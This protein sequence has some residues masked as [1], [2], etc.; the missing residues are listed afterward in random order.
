MILDTTFD[1]SSE[2]AEQ[3]TLPQTGF[4]AGDDVDTLTNTSAANITKIH[5][6]TYRFTRSPTHIIATE[7]SV[8]LQIHDF[9]LF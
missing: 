2:A 1:S 7:S 9:F 4:A 8:S 3:S 6:Q 5:K